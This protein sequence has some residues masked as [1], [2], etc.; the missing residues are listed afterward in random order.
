M[1]A[2]FGGD[3]TA[4]SKKLP[5]KFNN[6]CWAGSFSRSEVLSYLYLPSSFQTVLVLIFSSHPI[7][8]GMVFDRLGRIEALDPWNDLTSGCHLGY[9]NTDPQ[10]T[11]K[12]YPHTSVWVPIGCSW[13][14][15]VNQAH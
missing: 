1:R 9:I 7:G 5:F 14:L 12:A 15:W 2:Q 6:R 13:V 4:G 8:K 10:M 11:V 3:P